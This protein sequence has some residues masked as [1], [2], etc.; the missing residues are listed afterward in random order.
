MEELALLLYFSFIYTGRKA[1]VFINCL[2]TRNLIKANP[3]GSF[4][5]QWMKIG[6]TRW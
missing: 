5:S 2:K 4:K 6:I 1:A 3:P